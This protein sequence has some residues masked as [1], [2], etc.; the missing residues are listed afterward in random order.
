MSP[1]QHVL[2]GRINGGPVY[3]TSGH[4]YSRAYIGRMKITLKCVHCRTPIKIH[5][6]GTVEGVTDLCGMVSM[7]I[8]IYVV[9]SVKPPRRLIND[10]DYLHYVPNN[11]FMTDAMWAWLTRTMVS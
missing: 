3:A 11:N 6:D 10:V 9:I 5:R 2:F 8:I 7:K 1:M 4:S